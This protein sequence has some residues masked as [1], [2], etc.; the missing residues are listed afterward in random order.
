MK[1]TEYL[2]NADKTLFSFE[3]LPPLKG[4][5]LTNLL[6]GIAPLMD[7]N[8]PF[9][10]VTYHR[11]EYMYKKHPNGLLEKIST[12]KRP[13]T[14]GICAAIMNKF[15]V[16]AVPHLLCGGFSKEETE[17]ALIDLYF[18]G[19]ENVLALRGDAPKLE[20]NFVPEKDG[21]H[22]AS[23]LVEQIIGMNHGK[24]LHDETEVGFQTDFCVGVAGYPEK[25]FEAPSLNFDLKK[26]QAK[27]DA[28]ADYI[29]TQMFF[30]NQKYFDFVEKVRAAGIDAPIIP[31][32]KP[33]TTLSQIV[34]LP[35]TFFLDLPDDLLTALE[36]CKSN[37]DVKAV[38]IEW[39][40]QQS[41]E[42]IKYGVPTLHYYTMSKAD[43][44]YKV[45]KEVF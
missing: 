24:Y 35:K 31:G 26:L 22:Y 3:I 18:I 45:A 27:I 19:V 41:K 40:I 28:G 30:D 20:S 43:T 13:G 17:N 42:L 36:K 34:N 44:T 33:I 25:H 16:D 21:H 10:D 23:Q 7:F 14:V 4:Q 5:S 2:K 15:K 1:V 11:E 12:R 9:I 39:A 29:V 37:A 32:L 6:D 8:P 38:G